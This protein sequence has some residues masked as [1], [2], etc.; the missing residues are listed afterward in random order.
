MEFSGVAADDV[1]TGGIFVH[2][3]EERVF[4]AR[5]FLVDGVVERIHQM[6]DA[7][8]DFLFVHAQC[9]FQVVA[10]QFVS[11]VR[12]P[13]E[14]DALGMRQK[15]QIDGFVDGLQGDFFV[16]VVHQDEAEIFRDEQSAQLAASRLDAQLFEH[17]DTE[18]VQNQVGS[19]LLLQCADEP[20]QLSSH[21]LCRFPL[22][23]VH[24]SQ[25]LLP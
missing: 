12:Q 14:L 1:V 15:Q 11:I 13:L 5:T 22:L 25:S 2:Q 8:L 23:C 9:R 6:F 21:F 10:E 18:G 20:P 19:V 7:L 17:G 3:R 4:D 16:P 24:L